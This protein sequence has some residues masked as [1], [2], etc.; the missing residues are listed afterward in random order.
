MQFPHRTWYLVENKPDH[1]QQLI[2]LLIPH[3]SVDDSN[4]MP[5]DIEEL[6]PQEATTMTSSV[7]PTPLPFGEVMTLWS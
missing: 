4:A 2:D 1:E 7:V 6:P 3:S 5:T